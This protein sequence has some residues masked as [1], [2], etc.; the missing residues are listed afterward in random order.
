LTVEEASGPDVEVWPDNAMTVR[1]FCSMTTQ[2]RTGMNGATG[3]DYNALG[4]VMTALRVPQDDYQT[5]FDGVRVMEDAA[6]NKIREAR[7]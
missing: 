4:F 1:V 2:W 6:L 5:V 7:Q 3:L